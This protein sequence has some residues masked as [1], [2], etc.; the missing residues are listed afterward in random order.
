MYSTEKERIGIFGGTFDPV[1]M[2]HLLMAEAAYTQAG[3]SRVLFMP[4][5]IQPFKQDAETSS[6]DD[7]IRMLKMAIR[8]NPGFGITTIETDKG[9]VSYT[10]DSLRELRGQY[11][12]AGICFLIGTDMFLMIDKWKDA[13][14]LLSE[15]DFAVG[16]R[17][18]YRHDEALAKAEALRESYGTRI[19]LI[20]NPPIELSSTEIRRRVTGGES[21]RYRVPESVRRFLLVREKVGEKRLEHT[22][23]VIDLAVDMAV[24]FGEDRE[25]TELA[26]LLH[27]YSKDPSGGVANDIGHGGMAAEAVRCDFGVEDEDVLNAIRYHTTGRAGMSRLERIIFLADTVEPGRT[28][29]SIARLRE[30]CLDD[31]AGGTL[32]VL[33][34]LK[35]YLLRKGLTV[36]DDTEEAIAS[37]KGN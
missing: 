37:L 8:E 1:H 35:E 28:Y 27:D 20:D 24:R 23:R 10:I 34:E 32:S 26:A 11:D 17:P 16:V 31:L 22:K 5:H 36:S 7:R 14:A 15:F 21:I 18:G 9:G 12:G 13:E 3:L 30:T 19:D 6:D 33:V 25:K 2:G 4:A 29:D